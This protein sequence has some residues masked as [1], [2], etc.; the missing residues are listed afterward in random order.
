MLMVISSHCPRSASVMSFVR[1][2]RWTRSWIRIIRSVS[3]N[4]W[5]AKDSRWTAWMALERRMRDPNKSFTATNLSFPNV[6]TASSRLFRRF[7]GRRIPSTAFSW[8]TSRA[9]G[10][11]YRSSSSR[12]SHP[13]WMMLIGTPSGSQKQRT[14]KRVTASGDVSWIR[15]RAGVKVATTDF[16][17]CRERSFSHERICVFISPPSVP[18]TCRFPRSPPGLHRFCIHPEPPGGCSQFPLWNMPPGRSP[19]GDFRPTGRGAQYPRG[20]PPFP[21]V[22]NWHRR[23]ASPQHRLSLGAATPA[24]MMLPKQWTRP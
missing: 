7:K 21:F 5:A 2:R 4:A 17:S 3:S 16:S 24:G 19:A 1:S 18:S 15:F 6:L 20:S 23:R 11:L 8:P 14:R 9:S 12:L 10:D 13:C 22:P